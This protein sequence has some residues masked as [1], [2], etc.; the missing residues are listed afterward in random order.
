MDFMFVGV[1]RQPVF[2][3]L[4]Y[5]FSAVH[6]KHV[7]C[8]ENVSAHLL[9]IRGRLCRIAFK[10][11][12]KQFGI[13][14]AFHVAMHAVVFIRAR[15]VYFDRVHWRRSLPCEPDTEIPPSHTH[16]KHTHGIYVHSSA[17]WFSI[18]LCAWRINDFCPVTI[19][20]LSPPPTG[21]S[22]N[23]ASVL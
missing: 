20:R 11:K 16:T 19:F 14:N 6:R 2:F 23:H 18:D 21:L 17:I 15:T 1:W 22:L 12:R 7:N 3:F 4:F 10:Y 9:R 13:I 5:F 8:S